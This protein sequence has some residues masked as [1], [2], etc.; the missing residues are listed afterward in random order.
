MNVC[1]HNKK[2]IVSYFTG[3]LSSAE[4]DTIRT[5]LESCQT[6][7]QEFEAF[8][9]IWQNLDVLPHEQPSHDMTARFYAMLDAYQHGARE[10]RYPSTA[11]EWIRQ[12][13]AK[14]ALQFAF[15]LALVVIGFA[16]G[17]AVRSGSEKMTY[18]KLSNELDDMRE[19]VLLSMLKQQS[20]ADRL[21]AVNYSYQVEQPR[22][23][24][25]DALHRTLEYDPNTNVRLAA[26]RA[27]LPYAHD[28]D[29]RRRIIDS[30][31]LQ[32]SPLVQIEIID[33]VGQ[34]ETR[35]VEMLNIL[36]QEEQLNDAVRQHIKWTAGSLQSTPLLKEIKK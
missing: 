12:G 31:P 13:F 23:D 32:T 22:A 16:L 33:F 29:V 6:C 35:P 9:A 11:W 4:H 10:S 15:S 1:D 8:D 3:E 24:I 18:A 30:F 20:S 21:Q 28:A 36:L 17:L 5:H 34:T 19:I 27:L 2:Q 25:R 26:L 14:P 7:R